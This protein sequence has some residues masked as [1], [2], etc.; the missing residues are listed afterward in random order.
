MSF[1]KYVRND[2]SNQDFQVNRRALVESE[3][4]DDELKQI[5]EK[6]WIYAGHESEIK[7]IGDFKTRNV[8]GR[9]V[10]LCRDANEKVRVYLNVCRHRAAVVCR[11]PQGNSKGFFCFYHGWSY[12]INGE[13]DGVPG[14]ASYPPSF[15]HWYRREWFLS[16]LLQRLKYLQ[17]LLK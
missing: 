16:A 7:A 8:C 12:N 17:L 3:V 9:P 14:K 2:P 15:D 6:C 13:L 10:I 5:F 1:N 4:L 11:E